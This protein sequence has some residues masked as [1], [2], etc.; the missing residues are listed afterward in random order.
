MRAADDTPL[1]LAW[2]PT[3]FPDGPAFGDPE[4]TSWSNFCGIVSGFRR[5]GP[6]DGPGFIG[7]RFKL[8]DDG[9]QVRR[10]KANLTS[11]SVITM[12]LEANKQTGE[13]PPW[14]D[15]LAALIESIG[16]AAVIWT[17]HNHCPPTNI[18]YRIVS[19]LSAEIDHDLP[20]VEIIAGDLGIAGVLDRSKLGAASFFYLPSYSGDDTADMHLEIIVAGCAIDAAQLTKRAKALQEYREAEAN[21]AAAEAHAKA[22]A[23]REVLIA[24]GFDPDES[25]IEKIRPKLESLDQILRDHGYDRR[26]SGTAAKYRHPAS[27]S[28]SYGADIKTYIGIERVY[29]HNGGDLLHATQLPDWCTVTAVDAFDVIAILDFGGDRKKALRELAERYGLSRR[30]Q[31]RAL[32]RLI[33]R[34]IRSRASQET[35]EACAYAEGE[36]LGLTRDDVNRVAVWMAAQAR[37]EAG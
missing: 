30:Q 31:R 33:H 29:S 23:R 26:G 14:P 13:L 32:A 25:L 6:K 3:A 18:R 21:K 5:E 17:S 28:G 37:L 11:R 1:Q 19:P 27:Q 34:L 20:A 24:A 15:K 4:Q 22:A 35:V 9:K 8:E 7:A 10:L 16:F 36:R 12:D 2:F